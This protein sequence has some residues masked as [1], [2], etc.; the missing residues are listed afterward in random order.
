MHG[1]PTLASRNHTFDRGAPVD[2]WRDAHG[3]PAPPRDGLAAL[4]DLTELFAFDRRRRD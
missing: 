3:A 1:L 4:S 2:P